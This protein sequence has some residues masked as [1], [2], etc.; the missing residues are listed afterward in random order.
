[1]Y[2][3]TYGN[4][5]INGWDGTAL[6]TGDG[7]YVFAPQVGAGT[8][9]SQNRFTGVVMGKDSGQ[10]KVGLYGYQEGVNTFGLMEDGTAFFGAS[11]GGGRIEINGKSGSIKGGGGGNN[12][13]GMTINFA[14]LN[15]GNNTTAIKIGGGVFEVTYDGT[16]KATSATIEGQIFAQ[17]GKIGCTS[18]N[19]ND[20]W[21]IEKNKLYSG[22]GATRVE[23]NSD[24]DEEFAIWAG[25]T[26]S[27]S[28]K[29]S[30]F[31]VSKKGSLYA[32]Q[33][34]I[35]GWILK[36][37]SLSSNNNKIGMAS[38]GSYVF[39]SGANT[40]NPGDTPDFS[41][42]GTYFYVTNGGK[43]SCKNAEVR[44]NI[45][46][47]SLECD[48]GEIGGWTI[49]SN[50]LRGGSTYLYSSGRIVCDDLNCD[51]GNIGGWTIRENSI[52]ASGTILQSDGNIYTRLGRIGLV[53]GEDSQ[54][55]TYNFGMQATGGN[56][57]VIIQATYGNGNV[58][59]RAAN[60]IILNGN[61]LTC[62]VPAANQSGIYARFA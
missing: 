8:K 26:S 36:S 57:S 1:M 33:G 16:L 11:S 14:D 9:D 39:W 41:N 24:K 2:L 44:G 55:T 22:S 35:G 31:A 4:E 6:D 54:G 3:D 59:L 21:T 27:T 18:R 43:L 62:T 42:S 7:E 46:A 23:L 32:K 29:D 37:K 17:S 51:G 47:D 53:E 28:A 38:S 19:S 12:S 40:G 30:Y 50:S 56:G 48:N 52:S 20:G 25:A 10:D 45:T 34:N 13:A 61:R 5:A 15:P 49:S 60:Y 58:A